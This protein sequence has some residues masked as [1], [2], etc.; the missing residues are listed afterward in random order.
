MHSINFNGVQNIMQS[1]L[2]SQLQVFFLLHCCILIYSC[3]DQTSGDPSFQGNSQAAPS[4]AE[5]GFKYSPPSTPGSSAMEPSQESRG[6]TSDHGKTIQHPAP[7]Q[8]TPPS[9]EPTQPGVL[10]TGLARMHTHTLVDS[11]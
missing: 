3:L 6:P 1:K 4:A 11:N 9:T 8:E 10:N 7:T 5:P 2:S